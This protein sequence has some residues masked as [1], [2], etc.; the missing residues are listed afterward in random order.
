MGAGDAPRSNAERPKAGPPLGS[1]RGPVRVAAVAEARA[2]VTL[3]ERHR[4]DRGT[5]VRAHVAGCL[6]HLRAVAPACGLPIRPV[7]KH[8]PRSLASVRADGSGNPEGERKLSG[9]IP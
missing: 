1:G 6:Q 5:T 9:R 7:L 3:A 2:V 8:G 4:G